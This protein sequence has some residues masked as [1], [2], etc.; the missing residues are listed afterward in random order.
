MN[1]KKGKQYKKR[2]QEIKRILVKEKP[3]LYWHTFL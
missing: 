1:C 3:I 2:I